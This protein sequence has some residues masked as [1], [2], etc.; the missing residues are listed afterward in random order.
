MHHTALSGFRCCPPIKHNLEFFN[1]LATFPALLSHRFLRTETPVRQAH[2][3]RARID[4]AAIVAK[5][6][7]TQARSL[8]QTE[9]NV[10]EKVLPSPTWLSAQILP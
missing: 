3:F 10:K 7:N 4:L 9:G 8:I 6:G 5:P 2:H 1:T